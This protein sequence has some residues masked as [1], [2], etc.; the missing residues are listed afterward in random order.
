MA[1]ASPAR[2]KAEPSPARLSGLLLQALETELGGVQVYKA[3]LECVQNG[4][5]RKE[6][7][8]YLSQTERHVEIVRDMLDELGVDPEQ[9]DPGREVVRHIGEALVQAMHEAREAGDADAAE[10][11]AAECVTLAE[12]KDHLN[13]ELIGEVAR[14]SR[15]GE[16]AQ[17]AEASEKVE[18]EEDEHLYHTQGWTRELWLKALGLEAALPPPEEQRDVKSASAAEKAKKARARYAE[19]PS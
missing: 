17:L 5:L 14:A 9:E 1:K 16:A 15:H 13:W 10:I 19:N 11:V 18:E 2:D 12:T 3:A 7:R 6:W 4:D 8:K